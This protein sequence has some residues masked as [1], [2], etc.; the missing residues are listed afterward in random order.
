MQKQDGDGNN[1]DNKQHSIQGRRNTRRCIVTQRCMYGA[2]T[3]PGPRSGPAFR[4][5]LGH[6]LV[7]TVMTTATAVFSAWLGVLV[8]MRMCRGGAA[9][10]D[11]AGGEGQKKKKR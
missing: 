4:Q 11:S 10:G 2:Y 3:M 9:E 1:G 6:A 8:Y 7:L 5:S